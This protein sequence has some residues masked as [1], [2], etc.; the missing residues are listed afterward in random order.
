[1]GKLMRKQTGE[2][3]FSPETTG[4]LLRLKLC[5]GNEYRALHLRFW[6][7]H[8]LTAG[9]EPDESWKRGLRTLSHQQQGRESRQAQSTL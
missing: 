8:N 3:L 5:S 7:Q 6:W 2:Q 1:M 4:L 9:K